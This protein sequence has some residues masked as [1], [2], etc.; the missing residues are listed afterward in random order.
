[1]PTSLVALSGVLALLAV[2]VPA[3]W[4]LSRGLVTTLHEAGHALVGVAVGRRLHRIRLH[5]SGGGDT[6]TSGLPGGAGLVVTLAAGYPAPSLVGLGCAA[7]LGTGRPAQ[8]V[9][10]LGLALVAVLLAFTRNPYGLLL[11]AATGGVLLVALLR[12]GELGQAVVATGLTW[13]LLIGGLRS[14]GVL[15]RARRGR[16]RGRTGATDPDQ[17]AR[18]TVVPGWAWVLL[19]GAVNLA[20]LVL[21]GGLLLGLRWSV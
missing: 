11:L 17:L 1:M 5:G 9:L 12:A 6:L 21:G 14:V 4:G 10:A 2:A 15:R 3:C 13:F 18:L 20:A 8:A 16:S 19:F 7:W